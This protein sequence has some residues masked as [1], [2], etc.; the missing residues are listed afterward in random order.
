MNPIEVATQCENP[1]YPT[2]VSIIDFKGDYDDPD[3]TFQVQ[4]QVEYNHI[5][6]GEEENLLTFTFWTEEDSTWC[7]GEDE[8][9][10]SCMTEE[11]VEE[12][13]EEGLNEDL[14]FHDL[15]GLE[16]LDL[17]GAGVAY[18]ITEDDE[19]EAE[20]DVCSAIENIGIHIDDYDIEFSDAYYYEDDEE[21][22]EK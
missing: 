7:H 1:E 8:D 9:G 19:Y 15:E 21:D 5:V 14:S 6:D 22:E 16:E 20:S 18:A 4:V 11:D 3:Y 12:W 17:Y 13:F 10:E 2:R